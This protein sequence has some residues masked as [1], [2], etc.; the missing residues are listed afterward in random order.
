MPYFLTK[1]EYPY[2]PYDNSIIFE[3]ECMLKEISEDI[4]HQTFGGAGNVIDIG[5]I[6]SIADIIF[7]LIERC[8]ERNSQ[9]KVVDSIDSPSFIHSLVVRRTV[10]KQLTR[11]EW[12]SHGR[13]LTQNLINKAN[14]ASGADILKLV[15]EVDE[16]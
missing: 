13:D 9:N 4:A 12:R 2:V 3:K 6:T 16:N 8:R 14:A 1:Y 5:T 15:Q 10:R 11:Q 7:S